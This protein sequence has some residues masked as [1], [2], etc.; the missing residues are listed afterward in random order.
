MEGG[1]LQI[2]KL[3]IF[4]SFSFDRIKNL[5]RGSLSYYKNKQLH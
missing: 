4:S 1:Q 5:S 2:E 3:E